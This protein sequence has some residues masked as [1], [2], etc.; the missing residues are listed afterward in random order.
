MSIGMTELLEVVSGCLTGIQQKAIKTCVK[1]RPEK[2]VYWLEQ[3]SSFRYLI[4]KEIAETRW[5]A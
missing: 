2:Y 4:H 1:G 3:S 5:G